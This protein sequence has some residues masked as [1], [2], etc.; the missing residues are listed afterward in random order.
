MS[1]FHLCGAKKKKPPFIR[2][3]LLSIPQKESPSLFN[4]GVHLEIKFSI[5]DQNL[6]TTT[7]VF[8]DISVLNIVRIIAGYRE[9][10]NEC[11]TYLKN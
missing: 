6:V 7:L 10:E 11:T 5:P 4:S 9:K 1:F 2:K 3:T 8:V